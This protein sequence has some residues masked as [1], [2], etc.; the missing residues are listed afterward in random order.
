MVYIFYM[1][2]F[3]SIYSLVRKIWLRVVSIAHH[4]VLWFY[5]NLGKLNKNILNIIIENNFETR[6]FGDVLKSK[7]ELRN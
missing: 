2:I 3:N 6:G 5:P 7:E 4:I 1:G